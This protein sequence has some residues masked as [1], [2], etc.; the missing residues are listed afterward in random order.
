MHPEYD[1]VRQQIRSATGFGCESGERQG[2]TNIPENKKQGTVVYLIIE[3][4]FSESA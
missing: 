1:R 3:S 4:V 2:A